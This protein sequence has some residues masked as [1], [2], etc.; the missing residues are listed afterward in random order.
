MANYQA[1]RDRAVNFLL[2][3]TVSLIFNRVPLHLAVAIGQPV[4]LP[5]KAAGVR[6]RRQISPETLVHA[7]KRT[8]IQRAKQ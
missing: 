6:R 7:E 3:I 8:G 5:F 2:G 4:S 1:I